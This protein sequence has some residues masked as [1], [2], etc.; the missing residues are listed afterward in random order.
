MLTSYNRIMKEIIDFKY[1]DCGKD[2]LNNKKHSHSNCY[3]MLF[4]RSGSGTIM[5]KDKLFDIKSGGLYFINGMDIHCSV[6]EKAEEYIRSKLVIDSSYINHVAEITGAFEIIEDLF[7][8]SGGRYVNIYDT[9]LIDTELL[10]IKSALE[11]NTMYTAAQITAAVFNIFIL[12][13]SDK[14]THRSA[15]S[16]KVSS[17]LDFINNRIEQK[18]TLDDISANVHIGK[19]YM[20]H[21]FKNTVGM[22]ISEY[23]LS[24]RISIA[25]KKLLYTDLPISEIALSSGFSS[26]A[27]FSKIFREYE[28][29]T[30]K[31][32][33]EKA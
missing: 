30:P 32:F 15:I 20:C 23:I 16:N 31:E 24:R 27:Y 10:K 17:I 28:G 5:V 7:T 12:A 6:P 26:F 9:D 21:L 29:V 4:V 18:I 22:T 25:K 11:H 2:D 8:K 13:H 1:L 19:Y 14:T 33:R 3:E